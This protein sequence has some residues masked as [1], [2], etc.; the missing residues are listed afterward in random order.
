MKLD[1]NWFLL[2]VFVCDLGKL[3][4]HLHGMCFFGVGIFDEASW[5]LQKQSQLNKK[6]LQI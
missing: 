3:P 1:K 5:K 4:I 2:N 6:P